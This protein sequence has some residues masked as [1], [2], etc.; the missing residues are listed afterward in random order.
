VS[1]GQLL[2]QL[3]ISAGLTQE[4]LA[5]AARLSSR[6]VSDLE[7]GI[8]LTARKETARLL[9]DALNLAG[10]DRTA[11]E[12]AARGRAPAGDVTAATWAL[13][14]D[15][16]SFTGRESEL[17][18]LADAAAEAGRVACIYAIAGTAGVGKTAFAVHAAHGLTPRFPDGQIFLPLHGNTRGQRP[19]DPTNALAS[20]L[21]TIGVAAQ[22]IPPDLEGRV[23]LWRDHLV[24]RG[25]LL[26]LDD[27]ADSE[28][29]RPLLPATAGSLVLITSR[30]HLTAL[31]DARSISLDTLSPDE[32]AG[33]LVR[34]AAQPGIN[35]SDPAVA[36]ISRLCGY[37]PL[38]LGMLARQLHDHPALMTTDP[39]F[40]NNRGVAPRFP[41]Y[42][43]AITNL[44]PRNPA[45]S[46][47]GGPLEELHRAITSGSTAA[48]VQQ[49]TV[50]GLGGVG[51]TQLAVEYAYRH[52][53]EYDIAW[54]IAAEQP[55]TIPGQLA[56]LARRLG[57]AELG[58]QAQILASLWD[59]LRRRDRWLLVYDNAESLKDLADYRPPGGEGHVVI[60]SR[61]T[62]W[63]AAA[64]IRLD[65]L[66]REEGVAFLG[67]RTGGT[68]ERTLDE[69]AE[70]LGDLPLALE[71]AAAYMD[72][73]KTTPSDYLDLFRVHETELLGLG[74]PSTTEQTVATVW[75]VSLN[76]V[77]VSEPSA[78]DLLDL[79]AFLAPDAISRAL[80]SDH[81]AILP[82][83]LGRTVQQQL[84]YYAAVGVIA[85]YS[86]ISLT[87]KTIA[88]HRL[89]Q[90][91]TRASM[92][93]EAQE[94]WAGV[95]IRLIFTAFPS[96]S[97]DPTTWTTCTPLLPHALVTIDHA[98][99]L[100]VELK[101][102]A[103]LLNEVG[104]YLW[105]RSELIQARELHQRALTLDEAQFD[106]DQLAVASSLN[107]LGLV[108]WDLVD[109]DGTRAAHEKALAI[110][111]AQLGFNHPAVAASLN[112]LGVAL[113]DLAEFAEARAAHEGALAILQ[114]RLGNDHPAVAAS[115]TNLASVLADIGELAQARAAYER[116]LAI[117]GI[118]SDGSLAGAASEHG[119]YAGV[120]VRDMGELAV[121][122]AV[123]DPPLADLDARQDGEGRSPPPM[124][125]SIRSEAR[126]AGPANPLIIT[127]ASARQERADSQ[128]W[129]GSNHPTAAKAMDNLGVVLTK[130]GELTAARTIFEHVLAIR[131][132]RLGADHPDVGWSLTNL[133]VV[134]A[135]SGDLA[136]SRATLERGLEIREARL[137]ADH[138]DVATN[139]SSLGTVLAK[140]GDL[141]EARRTLERAAA[142]RELMLG[143][144]HPA[145]RR[146]RDNLTIV[147][148]LLGS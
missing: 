69:L 105:A 146:T 90:S 48:V 118:W 91:V 74:D 112:N 110:R 14:H 70:S 120:D 29:V 147:V 80:L 59:E 30:S 136:E 95:A 61:S 71:Q 33:L 9:A 87:P 119:H 102:V 106:T 39:P 53:T 88:I 76:R 38:A 26:L 121:A 144:S 2:R 72:E 142:I 117:L 13:P 46:G 114:A 82:E 7:R 135:K 104:I 85:R 75:Q 83:T 109:L 111:R 97:S 28:Q 92:T 128:P 8:N 81:A 18:Q 67:F 3:R 77:R 50:H 54:W 64:N 134:I 131:E 68:D 94:R 143:P 93:K 60:T 12:S 43:P 96:G 11:F 16:A 21:Q 103:L 137:G 116:A 98:E 123:L 129:S 35:L 99:A 86:L 34:L 23:R 47:R 89:V 124:R 140:L 73:T 45:F 138:P 62:S 6:S 20:L 32:A 51:K 122:R 37:L 24:G 84:S 25:V 41:G 115:L 63:G 52:A 19:T 56:G 132:A 130:M 141:P 4:E 139:L 55:V 10:P 78:E 107:N 27:A 1:F 108:L 125:L 100:A 17:Q 127:A 145:T 57:I 65:V 15:I 42:S 113:W 49:A 79:C 101:V 5:V 126:I 44:P 40:P 66:R 36:E 31:E 22:Q 148:S 58:D 133:G